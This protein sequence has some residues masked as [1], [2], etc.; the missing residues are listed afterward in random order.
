MRSTPVG[1]RACVCVDLSKVCLFYRSCQAYGYVF[2]GFHGS[3]VCFFACFFLRQV[4]SAGQQGYGFLCLV[5][6]GLR[7]NEERGCVDLASSYIFG[8]ESGIFDEERAISSSCTRIVL[9][10]DACYA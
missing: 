10:F 3:Y 4:S 8:G 5:G 6:G 9:D 2:H 7:G 1:M